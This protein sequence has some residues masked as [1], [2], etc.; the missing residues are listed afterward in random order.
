M[1]EKSE[2]KL[3]ALQ[4]ARALHCNDFRGMPSVGNDEFLRA[5]KEDWNLRAV[6]DASSYVCASPHASENDL[7]ASGQGDV[8]RE[9]VPRLRDYP[10]DTILEI[11]CGFGR[12]SIFIAAYC[13]RFYGVDISGIL[14]DKAMQRL[15]L[16]R[17]E[18]GTDGVGRHGTFIEVDGHTV[19]PIDD[20]VVDLAFEYI[21][22]QHIP[23]E[24]VI[25]SYIRD[26]HR[27]LKTGG[28][29]IMHGRDVPSEASSTL[30]NTWHGC[31]CGPELVQRA[32]EGTSFSVVHE[33]G[34]DTDRYWATLQK[35]A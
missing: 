21:V 17:S 14:I 6:A 19:E 24:D 22:F 5:A 29:F 33:E 13:T 7:R 16:Y 3:S 11:G 28:V 26:V 8:L 23:S 1:T 25:I 15:A 12:M 31:R 30:G 2:D 34:V 9:F 35:N 10:H 27:V 4:Y 32:I 20:G 18:F